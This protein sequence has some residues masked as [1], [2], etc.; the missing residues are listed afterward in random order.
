MPLTRF[1]LPNHVA[2]AQ[3]RALADVV[4]E[5]L[6]MACRVPQDDRFQLMVRL[7]PDA[8]VLHPTF[9]GVERSA[10]ACIV[11]ILFLSGRT[12][13]QKRC[14]YELVAARAA[15]VG[16]RADDILI[17]LAENE[18][19]DWSLGRGQAYTDAELADSLA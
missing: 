11:E 13:A 18:V 5:A 2:T 9:G 16:W 14:F 6:V 12:A 10:D 17:G 7:A 4:H 15:Q 19:I 8:M 3:A 1:Y